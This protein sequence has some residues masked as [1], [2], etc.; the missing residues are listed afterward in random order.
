MFTKC[1][2]L[3]CII[4]DN[5]L[6]DIN[7]TSKSTAVSFFLL[8]FKIGNWNTK[9]RLKGKFPIGCNKSLEKCTFQGAIKDN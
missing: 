7:V 5:V 4:L 3:K 6:L 1:F 9:R 2:L 8:V